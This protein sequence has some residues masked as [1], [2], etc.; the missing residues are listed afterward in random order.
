M[1]MRSRKR[2]Y[3][4]VSL[5]LMCSL[6]VPGQNTVWA[7]EG[8][9]G[10]EK[11]SDN[12]ISGSAISDDGWEVSQEDRIFIDDETLS[13]NDTE[14]VEEESIS[15]N[16]EAPSE[17]NLEKETIDFSK[18]ESISDG[19]QQD[20][21][22]VSEN[23]PDDELHRK[24]FNV[25]LPTE[26]PFKVILLGEQG[27][28]GV[29]RSERFCIENKGYEDVCISI[30]GS[31]I[32]QVEGE[33]DIS[34]ISVKNETVQKKTVWMYLKWEGENGE[35]MGLTGIT[36]GDVSSPGEG[37]IILKAPIRNKKGEVAED[38]SGSK[39][40]FS[41]VGD[42]NAGMD[43]TWRGDELSV[44]L[45][46]SIEEVASVDASSLG[47]DGG[48]PSEDS[49]SSDW[50]EDELG[51]VSVSDAAGISEGPESVSNNVSGSDVQLSVS[52]NLKD[53][54]SDNESD[55]PLDTIMSDGI[56]QDDEWIIDPDSVS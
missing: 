18:N 35:D 31:C 11:I 34:S 38:D 4:W 47:Y 3:V 10:Q 16:E 22:V 1:R 5:L 43:G 23:R 30:K 21:S 26:V 25:V 24:A 45:D 7:D 13:G 49:V 44:G 42:L 33:Y 32:G 15:Q 50:S 36:M 12:T 8:L 56:S 46:Y 51:S 20:R 6:C 29:I 28:R 40:F 55:Q 54:P 41:F 48:T 53:T 19:S 52:E 14:D 37:E 17:N 9:E 2:R 27:C 39:V